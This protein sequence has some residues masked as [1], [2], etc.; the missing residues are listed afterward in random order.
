MADKIKEL[1]AVLDLPEDSPK[2]YGWLLSTIREHNACCP[3]TLAFRLRD[4]V[5]Y[6]LYLEALE[7]VYK[8]WQ[9]K[10]TKDEREE[11]KLITFTSWL[12][13]YITA[14][15]RIIAALIVKKLTDEQ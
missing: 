11:N 7:L 13:V 2:Q 5:D 4:E 14:I 6:N 15:D 12:A 9:R 10:G 8:H 3:A 1:L